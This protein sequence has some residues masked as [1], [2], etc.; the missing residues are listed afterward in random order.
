M[1]HYAG[2]LVEAVKVGHFFVI[3]GKVSSAFVDRFVV[4]LRSPSA[5]EESGDIQFDMSVRFVE[6]VIARNSMTSRKG[7]W[8][9][10][11]EEREENLLQ[12][13]ES[14]PFVVGENFKIAI[15]VDSDAF[16]V[17]LNEKPFCT[18]PYRLSY[19]GITVVEIYGDLEVIYQVDHFNSMELFKQP[20]G[21]A[22]KVK[23]S[24]SKKLPGVKAASVEIFA[25]PT[26][27][28]GGN[29]SIYFYNT[30]AN[31]GIFLLEVNMNDATILMMSQESNAK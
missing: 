14:F 30:E 22:G 20:F 3:T 10:G 28:R 19:D 7:S 8:A 17:T 26:G 27:N 1:L 9:P 4:N 23:G 13:N 31:R 5:A 15:Y 18:F 21:I 16:F 11:T 12:D 2:T 24:F 29:F 6:R 25:V